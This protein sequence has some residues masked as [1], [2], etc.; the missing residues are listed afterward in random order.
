MTKSSMVFVWENFGPSHCDRC[1]AVAKLIGNSHKIVGLEL[2][3]FARVT[4]GD[5]K[6][7]GTRTADYL[8]FLGIPENR[9]KLNYDTLHAAEQ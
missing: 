3:S 7:A 5:P 9:I 6:P 2:A 8:R 4:N 1:E